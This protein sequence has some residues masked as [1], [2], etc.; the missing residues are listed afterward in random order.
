[1]S[2]PILGLVAVTGM[3]AGAL[4]MVAGHS[5]ISASSVA[6]TAQ[7]IAAA[8]TSLFLLVLLWKAV[9][10]F[11][12]LLHKPS[13]AAMVGQASKT[14]LVTDLTTS[15]SEWRNGKPMSETPLA[16]RQNIGPL[17]R[18]GVRYVIITL[19]SMGLLG[20]AGLLVTLAQLF[21]TQVQTR[22]LEAQN[23]LLVAQNNITAEHQ[24]F[25]QST[26]LAE[27][28]YNAAEKV[29]LDINSPLALQE[30]KLNLLPEIAAI[31]VPVISVREDKADADNPNDQLVET[32]ISFPN[33]PRVRSL[34]LMYMKLDRV[35]ELRKEALAARS[36]SALLADDSAP[37]SDFAPLSGVSTAL[38]RALHRLGPVN[39]ANAQTDEEVVTLP[40]LWKIGG[41]FATVERVKQATLP[42]SIYA[43][44]LGQPT[45]EAY[46]LRSSLR[47]WDFRHIEPEAF[48]QIQAPGAL[49]GDFEYGAVFPAGADF[50]YA[51]IQ[52]INLY[53]AQ[54]KGA[55]FSRAQLQGAHLGG[56]EL[57]GVHFY[58]AQ[59]QGTY[60]GGALIQGADFNVAQILAADFR[61]AHLLGA[62]FVRAELQGAS[63]REAQIQGADFG[64]ADFS[65]AQ[66]SLQFGPEHW[67]LLV[68]GGGNLELPSALITN[69][70]AGNWEVVRFRRVFVE[71]E[72]KDLWRKALGTPGLDKE[73]ADYIRAVLIHAPEVPIPAKHEAALI[74]LVTAEVY[75]KDWERVS[76]R[77]SFGGA[78][79]AH[80]DGSGAMFMDT[81][82]RTQLQESLKLEIADAIQERDEATKD[83]IVQRVAEDT[84]R[85]AQE[86]LHLL[87]HAIT[88]SAA[89]EKRKAWSLKDEIRKLR[90]ATAVPPA[91][92]A[93]HIETGDAK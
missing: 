90:K 79:I 38:F 33:A 17:L 40:S 11:F 78:R 77:T 23:R 70:K 27:A 7:L 13:A 12:S 58:R 73:W 91:H 20:M 45:M 82:T 10:W 63:F 31:Q 56:A 65:A 47:P 54:I 18:N 28:E 37:E 85:E 41:S 61:G 71:K 87:D 34:L 25:E 67:S 76:L 6:T 83:S 92:A 86:T 26:A 5:F 72:L 14:N 42:T 80:K 57:Q 19:V 74:N 59:L 30:Q 93:P 21:L 9:K 43:Q 2:P 39:H 51:Q 3:V 15:W 35:G 52:G 64:L 60:F 48:R 1:M 68:Q 8:A 50:G 44:K 81:E 49:I 32:H 62:N 89:L 16:L 55:D 84:H 66:G 36:S 46:G 29:L 4:L 22:R 24:R 69:V 88:D 53:M 75:A